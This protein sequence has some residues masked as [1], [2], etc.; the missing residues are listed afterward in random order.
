[1]SN[2][3]KFM[4]TIV[5]GITALV[6]EFVFHQPKIA[7]WLIV[8]VGGITTISMFIGMVKTLK[9]GKYGVDVLAITAIVA[10]LC[11]GN[12]GRV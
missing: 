3:K 1:M 9:S 10:T 8:I 6:A 11:V 12:T 7:F 4:V 5:I 2:L